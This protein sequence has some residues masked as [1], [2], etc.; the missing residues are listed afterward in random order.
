MRFTHAARVY[1]SPVFNW[2]QQLW[3]NLTVAWP[4]PPGVLTSGIWFHQFEIALKNVSSTTQN[5]TLKATL[6]PVTTVQ[7]FSVSPTSYLSNCY[8][9]RENPSNFYDSSSPFNPV[10]VASRREIDVTFS[11]APGASS[12]YLFSYELY[13]P[14][15]ANVALN[16]SGGITYELD[17]TEDRG[18]L[19]GSATMRTGVGN[20][21]SL[22]LSNAIN[23]A[24]MF[25]QFAS[26]LALL[27]AG[28]AF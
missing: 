6:T 27:N 22:D 13:G 17:I 21:P 16:D 3:T 28:R 9:R 10:P 14:I 25:N 12:S 7:R 8:F 11:L 4:G 19:T 23:Q 20:T 2:Q 18:A 1:R 15:G 5:G 24:M 26:Q